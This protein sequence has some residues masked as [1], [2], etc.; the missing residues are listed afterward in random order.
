MNFTK[1]M[2]E[3]FEHFVQRI[4]EI[5][6][7]KCHD[8]GVKSYCWED[9]RKFNQIINGFRKTHLKKSELDFPTH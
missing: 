1:A 4:I 6:F 5:L 2:Q 8:Q 7:E 9:K 3:N